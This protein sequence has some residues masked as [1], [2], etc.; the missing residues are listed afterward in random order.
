MAEFECDRD[1]VANAC[2]K[3]SRGIGYVS[4]IDSFLEVHAT[5]L[6]IQLCA[7]AAIAKIIAES[8]HGSDLNFDRSNIYNALPPNKLQD[9]W[10]L[11]LAHIL[12]E[13]VDSAQLR[14]AL[15]PVT[16]VS[17]NYDRCL[18]WFIFHAL[19]G[20]YF[21][22]DA[23]ARDAA[24][25]LSIHHPYGHVGEPSWLSGGIGVDFGG[26]MRGRL[27]EAA[28]RLWTFTEK[29]E[30]S[31]TI[32]SIRRAISEADTIVFLGFAFHPQNMELLMPKG[33]IAD[34][35]RVYGTAVGMSDQDRAATEEFIT[36]SFTRYV[37]TSGSYKSPEAR[38]VDLECGEFMRQFKRT[39]AVQ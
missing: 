26:E 34:V 1:R 8:E 24:K 3:I 2:S 22:D 29:L 27:N 16:F 6:D 9:T 23:E 38:L 35:Q 19:R 7:K 13:K 18:E 25:Q 14:Q 30:G 15:E 32:G 11:E 5:D 17:F 36:R 10:Y 21:L 37:E 33:T 28:K 31:E 39:L 20:L 12:F 4:S